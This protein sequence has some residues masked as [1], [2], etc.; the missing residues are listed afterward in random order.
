MKLNTKTMS[1]WINSIPRGMTRETFTFPMGE[2]EWDIPEAVPI[3]EDGVLS[4]EVTRTENEILVRGELEGVFSVT[5]ARCL[6]PVEFEVTEEIERIYSWDPE[7]LTDPEVE[8]V[9]HNDG[10]VSILDPVRESVIL[11]IP[12]VPLCDEN[13]RGLCP[14]C[15]INRNTE[16]C[17]HH[18]ED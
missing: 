3:S 18:I 5:C 15:G 7:M 17:E 4:L 8:P 2:T 12:S 13:C 14:R 9:S 16:Q 11:S 6:E 10:T 1:L